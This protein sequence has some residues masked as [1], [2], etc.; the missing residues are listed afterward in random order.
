M[1]RSKKRKLEQRRRVLRQA[2]PVAS[3][4]LVAISSAWAQSSDPLP[5]IIVTAQKREER[6]Q[7]VPISVQA[8]DTQQLENL[9]VS[10]FDE[11]VKYLPSV[12]FTN[13]APGF[14][15]AYFRG[16]ANGENNNHSGPQPTVGMYLDEQPITTIQ[17]ALDIHMYDMA[18]VEAL[19]GPQGTL[20]GASSMAGTIKLVTN[21]PDPAAFDAGYDIEGNVV[22]DGDTGYVV[23]GFTNI[24]IGENS[25]VRVVGW[26]QKG[27][28]YIDNVAG[29][30]TYNE[31]ELNGL[32]S[33]CIT[34]DAEANPGCNQTPVSAEDDF[35][36]VETYGARA[37]LR[38]DLN[39]RWSI[40]PSLMYQKQEADGIF[41]YEPNV[42]DLDVIQ[43]H[44]DRSEDEWYQAAL[45]VE[46]KVGDFDLLYTAA[47]LDR[48]D[49]VD[50]DYSDYTFY[51]DQ[52]CYYTAYSWLD[53]DG[54]M[55]PDPS[56]F[57]NGTDNYERITQEIRLTSPEIGNWKFVTGLFYQDTTHDIF[58]NYQI[59]GLDPTYTV[60]NWPD[61]IWLTNQERQNEEYA[62]FGEASFTINDQW[63]VVGG[64]R[65]YHTEDALKG[66]FGFAEGYSSNYGEALCFSPEEFRNSPCVNLD[67][68]VDDDGVLFKGTVNWRPM[69]DMLYYFT[70]SEGFRPGGVNRNGNAGPYDPDYLDNFEL[71]WKTTLADGRLRF[72]GAVFYE[73]WTDIQFSFLPPGGS[74]LTV[75]R[76][77]GDARIMGIEADID[78][79]ATDQLRITG[80]FAFIDAELAEDYRDDFFDP[81]PEAPPAASDGTQLPVTPEFKANVR[82][83]YE[84]M[85]GDF[86]SYLQLAT[87]Y[88]TR[89][90]SDLID[91]DREIIGSNDSY[92]SADFTAGLGRDSWG[93]ELFIDNV[94]DERGEVTKYAQCATD[95]CGVNPY[96]GIIQP[97]T[98][99]LRFNQ[100]FGSK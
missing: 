3:S 21:K 56:Q 86:D 10:D 55:L 99:G 97:M 30:R 44:P 90:Y 18:R 49:E 1:Q 80:G 8:I 93:I 91:A 43:F 57:I 77:A 47:Y 25:A 45:T 9:G 35:N 85:M 87:T 29:T 40:T 83:R 39:D 51:Y 95:V 15:L 98:A 27:A 53:G 59:S 74:G 26:Y 33:V 36:E 88:Q 73:D 38:I 82:A 79:A 58:Q 68:E 22:K 28:G 76:N 96:V 67:D 37:A 92:M 6:L 2:I 12:A 62:A 42:G 100:K 64:V 16:V 66:F 94:F 54:D 17:G 89:S 48:E 75:I 34:N 52:C 63:S 5:E 32:P 61:T 14:S 78:W 19:A 70:Y 60:A 81:D 72:N 20:Y 69:D 50:A 65:Y 23:E 11:Y 46:G 31:G 7:D 84:F 41:A 4:L 71:G 24:P 13:L